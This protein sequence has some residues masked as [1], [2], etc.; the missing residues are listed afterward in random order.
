MSRGKEGDAG[1]CF[2]EGGEGGTRL[3]TKVV[4]HR[5][6]HEH[7]QIL[8][9]VRHP[10]KA[11]QTSPQP[12]F[13]QARQPWPVDKTAGQKPVHHQTET[14]TYETGS[15]APFASSPHQC[16]FEAAKRHPFV[17]EGYSCLRHR[18]AY[19]PIAPSVP[20]KRD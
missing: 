16:I 6:S 8:I 20:T 18:R 12:S 14:P 4:N 15:P 1:G 10:R 17:A 3:V 7:A 19:W 9:V 5:P 2:K 13:N 11:S